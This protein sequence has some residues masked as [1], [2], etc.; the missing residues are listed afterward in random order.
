MHVNCPCRVFALWHSSQV[1]LCGHTLYW[2]LWLTVQAHVLGIRLAEADIDAL[3]DEVP[4]GPGILVTITAG[5]AL[6]GHVKE[7]VEILFLGRNKKT[8]V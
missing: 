2:A 7:C 5:K 8:S 4:H 1:L 3:L 6:V